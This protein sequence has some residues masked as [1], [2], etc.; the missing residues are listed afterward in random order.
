MST[1]V[2]HAVLPGVE[3]PMPPSGTDLATFFKQNWIISPRADIALIIAAPIL[4]FL[5]AAAFNV[6]FGPEVVVAIFLGFNIGHHLPT[7]MRIYGDTDLLKRFRYSL[8]LGPILPFTAAMAL[9]AYVIQSGLPFTTVLILAVILRI[10]DPWHFLMQ[11]FG[12]MRIY[13]RNNK[14]PRKLAHRMDLAISAAWFIHIMVAATEWLP[15]LLYTFYNYHALPLARLFAGGGYAL[16]EG[17]TFGVAVAMT[18]VYVG[19][20]LWCRRKGYYV[21]P[22]KLLLLSITFGVMYLTYLPN[23]AMQRVIPNWSFALG[24]AALGMVHVTQYLAIV[25]KYNRVLASR[26]DH[27]RVGLFRRFFLPGG[28]ILGTVYLIACLA[29]GYTLYGGKFLVNASV[30]RSFIGMNLSQW[31]LALLF[32]ASFTSTLMHYYYDGFIWKIRHKEN[33]QNLKIEGPMASGSAAGNS[34]GGAAR[35]VSWWDASRGETASAVLLRHACYFLLPIL[36]LWGTYLAHRSQSGEQPLGSLQLVSSE[37]QARESLEA[38][39][40]QVEVEEVMIQIRPL[41]KHYTYLAELTFANAVLE[42]RLDDSTL[43]P[44]R[45][46]DRELR[47]EIEHAVELMKT[48][49]ALPGPYG[50]PERSGWERDQ[51]E[52]LMDRW[53]SPEYMP[54]R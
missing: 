38:I 14:A 33:Q 45:Q 6:A 50:N 48:G 29:Y 42:H 36:L 10:W 9:S 21:S 2:S 34:S 23:A 1:G 31:L 19:Y 8:L 16:A 15:D 49:L 37:E 35:E 18:A 52:D 54:P 12:F 3:R 47:N 40:R 4:W 53:T 28:L 20:V 11:H 17:I 25:W 7:F 13:D 5:W 51:F 27:S 26:A 41:A 32:S 30:A 44:D 22:A 24:F 39:R 43:A 46:R